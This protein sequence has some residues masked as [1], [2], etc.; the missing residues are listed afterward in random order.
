[1]A[2]AAGRYGAQPLL[3]AAHTVRGHGWLTDPSTMVNQLIT[4]LLHVPGLAGALVWA[5]AAALAPLLRTG[6]WPTLDLLLAAAWGAALVT[7]LQ[8]VR[9]LPQHGELT[10]AAVG[11]VLLAWPALATVTAQVSQRSRAS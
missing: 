2:D 6:R 11:V 3:A 1:M 8:A 10:G 9:A 7:G 4:P 5:V